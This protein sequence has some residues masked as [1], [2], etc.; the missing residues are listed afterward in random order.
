MHK[1]V[2]TFST[3]CKHMVKFLVTFSSLHKHIFRTFFFFFFFNLLL[4]FFSTFERS[5]IFKTRG[6]Q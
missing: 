2:Q 3:P 5:L 6:F 1:N 4:Y